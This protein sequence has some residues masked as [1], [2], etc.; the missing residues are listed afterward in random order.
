MKHNGNYNWVMN[1]TKKNMK[2]MPLSCVSRFISIIY[3]VVSH[4]IQNI[5]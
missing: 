2:I 3:T 4:T 5:A 1:C